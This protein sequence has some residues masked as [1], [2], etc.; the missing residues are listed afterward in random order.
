MPT[1]S[2]AESPG[3]RRRDRAGASCLLPARGSAG[4]GLMPATSHLD[5]QAVLAPV[6]DPRA[7]HRAGGGAAARAGDRGRGDQSA[8]ADA[9]IR[10][11]MGRE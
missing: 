9:R 1:A 8:L 7:D 10:R 2:A 4:R 3:V 6:A 5:L 11:F